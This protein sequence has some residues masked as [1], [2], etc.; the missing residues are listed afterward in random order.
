MNTKKH[1]TGYT[2]S[3]WAIVYADT[4]ALRA[5][6]PEL[7]I[8]EGLGIIAIVLTTLYW[9]MQGSMRILAGGNRGN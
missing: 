9:A 1:T 5:F 2:L 6:S 3:F 7:S 4:F 8:T